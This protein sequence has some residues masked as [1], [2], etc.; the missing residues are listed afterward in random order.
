[1]NRRRFLRLLLA[2][3]GFTQL[4]VESSSA[5]DESGPNVKVWEGKEDKGE[6]DKEITV[7][8]SQFSYDPSVI[9]VR[10]GERVRLY[11]KAT[12]VIHGFSL[13]GYPIN[14]DFTPYVG[15]TVEF[16]ATK[17]GTFRFRCSHACGY[18][19]PFMIGK[20]EV[21]PDTRFY[22]TLSGSFLVGLGVVGWL[23][24][25]VTESNEGESGKNDSKRE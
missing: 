21:N 8:A 24:K 19:H 10:K 13:D 20:L 2:T 7:Q 23:W 25:K 5:P 4:G 18:F 3:L 16:T 6:V 17:E 12:D 11:L 1:M 9:E 14:V 22:S 15:K